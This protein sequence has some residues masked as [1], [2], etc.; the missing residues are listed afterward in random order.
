VPLVQTEVTVRAF[1]YV[2]RRMEGIAGDESEVSGVVDGVPLSPFTTVAVIVVVVVVVEG[3]EGVVL[4]GKCVCVLNELKNDGVVKPVV[5]LGDVII[6]AS[7]TNAKLANLILIRYYIIWKFARVIITALTE[8]FSFVIIE[9]KSRRVRFF[10]SFL[11]EGCND[12]I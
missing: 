4:R 12:R 2:V 11:M 7:T 1:S 5:S 9:K 3:L 6:V 8:R 10:F